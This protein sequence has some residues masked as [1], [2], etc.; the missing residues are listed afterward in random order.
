MVLEARR[1]VDTAGDDESTDSV[2]DLPDVV[3]ALNAMGYEEAAQHVYGT[4]VGEWKKRHQKKA[5]SEQM[6][7]YSASTSLHASH[8]KDLLALRADK[9]TQSLLAKAIQSSTTATETTSSGESKP[10]LSNVCC[11]DVEEIAPP[12][13]PPAQPGLKTRM[14][15]PFQA[16]PIPKQLKSPTTVAILTVSDRAFKN[17][18]ET[19]DLSGPA[20]A[21]AIEQATKSLEISFSI[22]PD[23]T[24]AIQSKLKEWADQGIDL[25]LTTGG[26]GMSPRDVTPEAT[27][28]VLDLECAGLMSFVTTECSNKQPLASLSRGTA[29]IRG[30]TL[31][32][33][34]PGNPKG[35]GEVVPILLP[36]LLHAVLDLQSTQ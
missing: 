3:Q 10:L 30:Q 24:D 5:T 17:E 32:A 12:A 4:T 20:V 9:P 34:L 6:E 22:V 23:E 13:P 19:G 15:A 1:M 14:L 29:G 36:L 8:D 18:Y 16:P 26:T 35:V 25:I 27:R 28:A 11:Q 21:K 2:S 7:K 33:N 31:I